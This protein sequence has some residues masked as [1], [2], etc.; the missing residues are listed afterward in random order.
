MLLTVV[1]KFEIIVQFFERKV[2]W[3][4]FKSIWFLGDKG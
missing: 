4:R 3:A 1:G 2:R